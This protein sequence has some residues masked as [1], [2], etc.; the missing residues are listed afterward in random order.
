MFE[1]SPLLQKVL[2][3]RDSVAEKIKSLDPEKVDILI[4]SVK[5]DSGELAVYQNTQA[6]AF[7]SGKLPLDL[8]QYVYSGIGEG[9][10]W[11]SKTSLADRVVITRLIGELIGI[12]VS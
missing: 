12:R 11:P 2:A 10:D 7:A 8:A 5:L 6:L 9:G 1:V 4:E 3:Q